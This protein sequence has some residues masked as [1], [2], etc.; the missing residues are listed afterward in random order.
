M[1]GTPFSL[2][3]TDHSRSAV[4]PKFRFIRLSNAAP[5]TET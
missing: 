5:G 3:I 1:F 4:S 2:A